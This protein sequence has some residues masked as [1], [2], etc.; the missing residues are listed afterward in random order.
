MASPASEQA[1]GQFSSGARAAAEG[2]GRAVRAAKRATQTTAN[3][4]STQP[5]PVQWAELGLAGWK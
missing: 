5:A 4:E 3:Q 1:S 2:L